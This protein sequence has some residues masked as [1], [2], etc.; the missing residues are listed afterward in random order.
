[1]FLA[2]TFALLG[3]VGALAG[4]ALLLRFPDAVRTRLLPHLLA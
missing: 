2:I 1:M 3:S 4:A